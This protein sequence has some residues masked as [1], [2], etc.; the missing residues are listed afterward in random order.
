MSL[1][2]A[3]QIG[4][5]GLLASQAAIE[6]AGNNLA[7]AATV[8]YHRQRVDLVPVGDQKISRNAF[9]G[10][11]VQI[12]QIVRQVDVSLENRLRLGLADQS[13]A[14]IAQDMLAQ[15]EV[16]H[17]ELSDNDLSSHLSAFF[18]AWSELAN[19]PDDVAQ[20]AMVVQEG[21][22]LAL[23]VR[24]MRSRLVDLRQ[25][26]DEQIDD[27]VTAVADLLARIEQLNTKVAEAERGA[28]DA[29]S[30]RDQRG[31]LL[32][33]LSKLVD[34]S[35][36]EADSGM[37]DVFIGSLPIVLNGKA[38][39]I[40]TRVQVVGA[41]GQGGADRTQIEMILAEDQS[42][43]S[44]TSGSLGALL[45]GREQT[46]VD[47]LDVLD[48]FANQ[49][50][51]Q[52]NRVHSQGQGTSAFGDVLGATRVADP[53]ALLNS[54]DAALG[55]SVVH[56]GFQIHTTQKSTGQ[57][58]TSAINV[59]LDGIDPANDTSLTSLVAQLNAVA[60]VTASV[61]TDG[62]LRI[63]ADSP[64][65][66]ITFSD[67]SSGALA[68]LG[69]NTFFTGE[70]GYDIAVSTTV[71]DNQAYVAVAQGHVAGDNR[72]ALAIAALADRPLDDLG[73]GSLTE[74]WSRGIE[75]QAV[76]LSQARQQ[77]ETETAVVESL[78]AQQQAL[79]GVNT[80]E[81]AIN[82]L[83]FQRAYQGSARFLTVVDELMQTLLSIL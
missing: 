11:G 70:G 73:G 21:A 9:V 43:L 17:N 27:A 33:D 25:Q 46:V 81:E 30:L 39:Q 20:R 66:E 44:P 72:N 31:L 80:D 61:T 26:V 23:F 15:I 42:V 18:S 76:R 22:S 58:D 75:D 40:D 47:A 83:A 79:S 56:G 69:I 68:A 19:A 59:D 4:R 13:G 38:Q 60:G 67:D 1:G 63:Q 53:G 37:V 28:G 82:L 41:A 10:R 48:G 8:G 6:V 24:D 34:I 12:S 65:I 49:L 7:N 78:S 2:N 14:R 64:D 51:F 45:A 16:I 29:H 74:L 5:T 52:V 77:V 50:I 71:R 3:L 35:V 32:S 54:A 55:F 57:R 62:R 36:I